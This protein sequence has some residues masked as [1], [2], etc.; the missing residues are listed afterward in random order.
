MSEYVFVTKQSRKTTAA[1]RK[2]QRVAQTKDA[3]RLVEAI[4]AG[5]EPPPLGISLV[6]GEDPEECISLPETCVGMVIGKKGENL[7]RIQE[8][9]KV[10]VSIKDGEPG[11]D[12]QVTISGERRSDVRA[13][14]R[15]LDYAAE[16]LEVQPG[17][18]GWV[19][20]KSGRHLKFVQDLT[21]VAALHLRREGDEERERAKGAGKG[22]KDRK[23]ETEAD[24]AAPEEPAATEEANEKDAEVVEGKD[25]VKEDERAWVEIKGQ[26]DN[27]TNARICIEAHMSYYPVFQEMDEVE[28]KLDQEIADLRTRVGR[29][30][31]TAGRTD[32][33]GGSSERRAGSPDRAG[34]RGGSAERGKGRGKGRGRGGADAEAEEG[35]KGGRG[36]PSRSGGRGRGA[37]K[38]NGP[39]PIGAS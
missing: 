30:A 13:A 25:T 32:G 19:V 26:R 8:R 14:V 5:I 23:A 22:K 18:T 28:R 15:E 11:E 2:E 33:A 36:S 35:A 29:R 10:K 1:L 38:Q 17:T 9:F 39:T 24:A 37:G 20:G 16:S 3:E 7:K 4:H 27:V 6:P 12:K 34:G 21:G 31:G